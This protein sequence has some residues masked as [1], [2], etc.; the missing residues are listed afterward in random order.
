MIYD[1]NGTINLK[2]RMIPFIHKYSKYFPEEELDKFY[3]Y[4]CENM[5]RYAH[6]KKDILNVI[7]QLKGKYKLAILSNGDS[8]QQHSKI[9]T[10][11]L[12]KHFDEVLVTGDIGI[13]K[14]DKRVFEMLADRL[15]VKCEE[16]VFIGDVFSSDIIG[17]IRA[18]MIPVWIVPDYERPTS[19]KGFR[20]LK[21]N[22]LLDVLD[23]LKKA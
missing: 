14:P 9:D 10:N 18:N 4:Y 17:A 5:Y 16:C 3:D 11:D 15:N 23:E 7:E 12:P 22:E 8:I 20:I 1:C 2:Y 13:H 19:Y 6:L 21:I